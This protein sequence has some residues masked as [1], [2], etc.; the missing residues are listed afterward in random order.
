MYVDCIKRKQTKYNKKEATRSSKLL[1]I[2]H[3]DICKPFDTPSFGGKK[4][5][6]AFIDNFLS[7]K[8]I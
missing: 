8:Y 1:E 7:Y 3:T 2:I 5:L 6:I 4:Y